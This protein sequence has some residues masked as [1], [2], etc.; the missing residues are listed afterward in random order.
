MRIPDH[1]TSRCG[2]AATKK[3]DHA[4]RISFWVETV[5]LGRGDRGNPGGPEGFPWRHLVPPARWGRLERAPDQSGPGSCGR[6]SLR[7]QITPRGEAVDA[8][9]EAERREQRPDGPRKEPA[10][11]WAGAEPGLPDEI[12]PARLSCHDCC[13]PRSRS[14][15]VPVKSARSC[16]ISVSEPCPRPAIPVSIVIGLTRP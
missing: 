4:E 10:Q 11:A 5:A 1:D 14:L 8:R 7:L 12:G 6:R 16:Q 9:G 2:H 15:P 13:S 3:R